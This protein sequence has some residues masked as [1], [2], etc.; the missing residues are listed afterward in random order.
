MKRFFSNSKKEVM[1]PKRLEKEVFKHSA[2]FC[3]NEG[4][5]ER[6]VKAGYSFAVKVAFSNPSKYD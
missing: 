6:R 1:P 4:N 5:V 2:V 3:T